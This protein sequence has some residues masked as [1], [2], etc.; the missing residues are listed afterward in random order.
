MTVAA[1]VTGNKGKAAAA[2]IAR[3]VSIALPIV[4]LNQLSQKYS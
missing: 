3:Y 1:I 2:L 4:A